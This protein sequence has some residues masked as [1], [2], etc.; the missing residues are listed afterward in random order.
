[1]TGQSFDFAGIGVVLPVDV[2][3]PVDRDEVDVATSAGWIIQLNPDGTLLAT[4]GLPGTAL[5]GLATVEGGSTVVATPAEADP[6]RLLRYNLGLSVS[7]IPFA[8]DTPTTPTPSS[9]ARIA[10]GPGTGFDNDVLAAG[11]ADGSGVLYLFDSPFSL[12]G[13]AFTILLP[14]TSSAGD[15]VVSP[16]GDQAL[17]TAPA[18]KKVFLVGLD[19]LSSDFGTI[20]ATIDLPHLAVAA[21][22]AP[23]GGRAYVV[24]DNGVATIDTDAGTLA[25]D[26]LVDTVDAAAVISSPSGDR[27]WTGD[28]EG[29]G[30]IGM[31]SASAVAAPVSGAATVGEAFSDAFGAVRFDLP[32]TWS[33]QPALPDGLALDPAT[34]VVSGTPSAAIA[35]TEYTV[36][37]SSS[38]GDA[39][40]VSWALTVSAAAGPVPSPSPSVPGGA[41]G[42]TGSGAAPSGGRGPLAATGSDA[43][44]ALAAGAL[45]LAGGVGV[46]AVAARRRVARRG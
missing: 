40:S 33:V 11:T 6:T 10:A 21:A 8:P 29:S 18:A 13:Q 22:W 24:G 44:P 28:A 34:G 30:G 19:P 15:M 46:W 1:M 31:L 12:S 3:V 16:S 41:S 37:A 27:V 20:T 43:V 38:D 5:A 4:N 2:A 9:L 42:G 7:P 23:S 17:V 26:V 14:G 45:L 25:S 39:V 36:S 35:G 32:V